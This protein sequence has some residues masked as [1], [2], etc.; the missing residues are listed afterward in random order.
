MCKIRGSW[1]KYLS[2]YVDYSRDQ[3]YISNLSKQKS[4]YEI[5]L[6]NMKDSLLIL[7]KE[8]K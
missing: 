3:N 5:E 6:V 7:D 8:K 1:T 4:Q 2:L